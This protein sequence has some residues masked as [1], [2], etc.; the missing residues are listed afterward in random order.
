[1]KIRRKADPNSPRK[2]A[3]RLLRQ[4]MQAYDQAPLEAMEKLIELGRDDEAARQE[5]LAL[6]AA[7]FRDDPGTLFPCWLTLVVGELDESEV[8]LLLYGI[9]A[10]EGDALNAAVVA[11]LMRRAGG[12]LDEIVDAFREADQAK[13]DL[14]RSVLYDILH[15]VLVGDDAAGKDRV[16]ELALARLEIERALPKDE[17][18]IGGPLFILAVLGHPGTAELLR[19]ARG[20]AE[21]GTTLAAE[22]DDVEAVLA[23]EDLMEFPRHVL[24]SDWRQTA[25]DLEELAADADNDEDGDDDPPCGAGEGDEDE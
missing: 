6:T 16:K 24:A 10:S 14:Y 18:A 9:G 23:G 20:L 1:M 22:L 17:T 3:E 13:D 2:Q 5:I 8:P 25:K 4:V 19:E 11:S 7:A 21:A 12:I 15:G